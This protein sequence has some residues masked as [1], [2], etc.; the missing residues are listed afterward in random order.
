MF[1]RHPKSV[2]GMNQETSATDMLVLNSAQPQTVVPLAGITE[3]VEQC[4]S[5]VEKVRNK[6]RSVQEKQAAQ[7]NARKRKGKRPFTV[8]PGDQVMKKN[9][10]KETRQG[11]RL[12]PNF[13]G[14]YTVKAVTSSGPCTLVNSAGLELATRYNISLMKPY[15]SQTVE[16]L[17]PPQSSSQVSPNEGNALELD[18]GLVQEQEAIVDQEARSGDCLR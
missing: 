13:T 3:I 18:V 8:C 14:P 2:D 7:Y 17:S 12:Q 6:M 11:G 5:V 15:I 4:H 16:Q 1:L 10:R 9:A